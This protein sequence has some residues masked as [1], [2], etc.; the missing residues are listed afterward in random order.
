[1]DRFFR[2]WEE[3]D[4]FFDALDRLPQTLCH[5]DSLRP[6]LFARETEDGD[7]QTVAVDWAFAGLG[8]IREGLVSLEE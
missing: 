5:L 1:M 3:R 2:L 8:A 7:Y 4:R 6:D